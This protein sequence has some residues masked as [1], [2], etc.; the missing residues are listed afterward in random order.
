MQLG[1]KYAAMMKNRNIEAMYADKP[2]GMI[3]KTLKNCFYCKDFIPFLASNQACL[4][5]V[6]LMLHK[7]LHLN[8]DEKLCMYV[9]HVKHDFISN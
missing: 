6:A 8:F 9:K 2:L 7:K 3:A 5:N 1:S 4:I